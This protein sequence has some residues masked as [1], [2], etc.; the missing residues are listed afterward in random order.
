[1]PSFSKV[2]YSLKGFDISVKQKN[3]RDRHNPFLQFKLKNAFIELD[4]EDL[5]ASSLT[6]SRH[7]MLLDESF[8]NVK[9]FIEA[10]LHSMISS[11]AKHFDNIYGS[12]NGLISK[13]NYEND[14]WAHYLEQKEPALI[15]NRLAWQKVLFPATRGAYPLFA[16]NSEIK[17]NMMYGQKKITVLP[18]ILSF[19]GD[20]KIDWIDSGANE[21][22]LGLISP[23][24]K[25]SI[26]MNHSRC[27]VIAKHGSKEMVFVKP[28]CRTIE[29]P[30]KWK[31]V[32]G[33][34]VDDFRYNEFL[35]NKNCIWYQYFDEK[36]Y[37]SV[38]DASFDDAMIKSFESKKYAYCF[39][40]RCLNE[41]KSDKWLGLCENKPDLMKGIFSTFKMEEVHLLLTAK[42]QRFT[43]GNWEE[44]A[45]TTLKGILPDE[46]N[47]SYNI[48]SKTD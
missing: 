6:V 41:Y 20:G 13:I 48:Y 39:L 4:I 1:M 44:N 42:I 10:E 43:F 2:Y 21:F 34:Q 31:T 5:E 12:I 8:L 9:K 35:I 32:V 37:E 11:N 18:E 19:T 40:L 46:I 7:Q 47:N 38:L 45:H 17:F 25:N 3:A 15:S 33:F 27:L 24:Y 29:M 16:G 36:I 28:V 22:R 14:Y 30:K 23:R 26:V